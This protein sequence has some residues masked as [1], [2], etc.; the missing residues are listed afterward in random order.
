MP[1]PS[2]IQHKI[3]VAT[4]NNG[5]IF[6]AYELRR[7]GRSIFIDVR[8]AE[9]CGGIERIRNGIAPYHMI[10]MEMLQ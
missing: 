7:E 8:A 2:R 4:D 6:E 1:E 3:C 10:V 5:N 9:V